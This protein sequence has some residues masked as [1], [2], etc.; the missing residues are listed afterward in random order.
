MLNSSSNLSFKNKNNFYKFK[1]T[2]IQVEDLQRRGREF[3]SDTPWN[4]SELAITL[5]K[6]I[7][8]VAK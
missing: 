5:N 4:V 8:M 6:I 3:K 1:A 2:M 7:I